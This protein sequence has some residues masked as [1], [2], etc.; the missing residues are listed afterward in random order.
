MRSR[1][2]RR[3]QV[4]RN[5]RRRLKEDRKQHYRQLDCP[6][7]YDPREMARFKEQPQVCS[8]WG[9][10]NQR[11]YEGAPIRERRQEWVE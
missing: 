11:A 4:Q 1:D 3:H 10:G 2:F 7:W 8:C 6:C 9:C 5:M